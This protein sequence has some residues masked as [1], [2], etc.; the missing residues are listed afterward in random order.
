VT[1]TD[2]MSAITVR[3]PWAQ[4]IAIGRKDIENR[5]RWTSHRGEVAIHAGR[6]IDQ[7]GCD[8]PRVVEL[9]DSDPAIG[10]ALG[11][12]IAVAE[13][14][15]CHSALQ[16]LNGTTCCR[17]WG[18]PLHNGQPGYHLVL[19]NVR[20]LW[21]PVHCRGSLPVPWTMTA[22]DTAKV[23]AELARMNALT[24]GATR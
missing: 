5:G 4:C 11:A 15:D 12:V 10:M 14:T 24:E 21:T 18:E 3:Q 9:Y 1:T 22:E 7:N 19:A 16:Y 6:T 13:L 2:L 23:R 17:P 20:M 8:D